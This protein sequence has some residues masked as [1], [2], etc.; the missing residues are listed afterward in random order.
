VIT[1]RYQGPPVPEGKVS[2]KLSLRFQDAE[3]T[4][5]GDDVQATVARVVEAL[6]R[7]GAVIR[8]E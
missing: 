6:A 8:G 2:L 3:R 1:D 4:L 7:S 5:T